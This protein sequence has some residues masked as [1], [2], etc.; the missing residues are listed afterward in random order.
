MNKH[1]MTNTELIINFLK[2]T[3][4]NDN[5]SNAMDAIIEFL[6]RDMLEDAIPII[7]EKIKTDYDFHSY[8]ESCETINDL[9][10][11]KT[12]EPEKYYSIIHFEN[13]LINILCA[14]I[15][16]PYIV[17]LEPEDLYKSYYLVINAKS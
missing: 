6:Q 5:D 7:I 9:I 14:L 1:K 17:V 12:T 2:K 11:L 13:I 4:K 16:M 10:A 8:F 15:E 3:A